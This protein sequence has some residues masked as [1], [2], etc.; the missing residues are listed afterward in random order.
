MVYYK[1]FTASKCSCKKLIHV[2]KIT[3]FFFDI[4]KPKSYLSRFEDIAHHAA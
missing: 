2:L 3:E 1:H 4:L